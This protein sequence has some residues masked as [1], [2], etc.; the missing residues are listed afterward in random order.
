MKK[1]AMVAM[2]AALGLQSLPAKAITTVSVIPTSWTLVWMPASANGG[3]SNLMVSNAGTTCS[4]G[5]TYTGIINLPTTSNQD[6]MKM[7]YNAVTLAKTTGTALTV[8][9][10]ETNV[11]TVVWFGN[12]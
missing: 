7:F 11:C 8:Q 12:K 1:L 9:Y 5:K 6:D 2:M 4:L 10:D 3:L